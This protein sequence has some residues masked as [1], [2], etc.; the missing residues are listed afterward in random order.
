M[1]PLLSCALFWVVRCS[2]PHLRCVF[3]FEEE[4]D[5][6]E[7]EEYCPCHK[8]LSTGS[9]GTSKNKTN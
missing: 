9:L 5:E 8:R 4:E 3:S 6:E 1:L 7:E 2:G